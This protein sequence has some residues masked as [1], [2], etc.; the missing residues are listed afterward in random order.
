MVLSSIILG[1][2]LGFQ[3]I[4]YFG[5]KLGVGII[6]LLLMGG[7]GLSLVM[8]G[9]NNGEEDLFMEEFLKDSPEN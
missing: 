2:L 7:I 4:S 9:H 3:I 6:S 1:V 5:A 8:A